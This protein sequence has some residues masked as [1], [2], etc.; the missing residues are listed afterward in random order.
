MEASGRQ[1]SG[2]VRADP[3]AKAI[4]RNT[5]RGGPEQIEADELFGDGASADD[6]S[7]AVVA[8]S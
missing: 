2:V 5:R 4:A 6:G 8:A 7:G 1:V 3:V